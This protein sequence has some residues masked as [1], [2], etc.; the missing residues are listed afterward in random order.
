[1]H[2]PEM[3]TGSRTSG[4]IEG[5]RCG[6]VLQLHFQ[7]HYYVVRVLIY[8][9]KP[10]TL[11]LDLSSDVNACPGAPGLVRNLVT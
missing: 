9:R 1:M 7:L 8:L 4:I 6:H 11:H 3:L 10:N 2:K 5:L